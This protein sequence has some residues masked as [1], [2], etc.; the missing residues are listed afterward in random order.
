MQHVVSFS[1]GI[2]SWA[3]AKRVA[4][5]HGT[6]N[7][8]LLFADTNMEDE[9][10]YRFLEDCSKNIG[11]PITRIADGRTP[12]DVFTDI[13]MM[14]N[15][16]VDPC[17]RILKRELLDAWHREHCDVEDTIIY[18]GISWDESHRCEAI[19]RRLA[20]WRVEFPM[21]EPPFLTK[22]E[23]VQMLNADGI[24]Q[25][26]L[27]GMGFPHNNCGGF[28]IKGGHSSFAL[29]LKQMP[30]RYAFHEQKEREF[31]E[32]AGKNV[33]ILRDRSNGETKPLTLQELRE[34]IESGNSVSAFDW[35]SCSCF[36]ETGDA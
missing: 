31:R 36:A 9:D 21:C 4:E 13:R 24:K 14:G 33:S 30:D 23:L 10:L 12:W 32:Q 11:I 2:V 26:R 6:E 28:C 18:V 34:R 16:R 7:L 20:P 5:K 17:S 27:Y 8:T 25:P 19:S 1:G 15:S 29:L 3:T 22:G 35:G